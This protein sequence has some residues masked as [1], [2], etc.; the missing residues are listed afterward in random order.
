VFKAIIGEGAAWFGA[1][2]FARTA[3]V[4]I[5]VLGDDALYTK[6]GE[7]KCRK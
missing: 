2:A 7:W 1:L 6:Q 5:A 4:K 3:A